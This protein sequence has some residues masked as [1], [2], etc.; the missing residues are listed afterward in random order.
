MGDKH[1]HAHSSRALQPRFGRNSQGFAMAH[2]PTCARMMRSM[3]ALWPYLPATTTHGVLARRVDTLTLVTLL[4]N[5]FFHHLVRG[6]NSSFSSCREREVGNHSSVCFACVVRP[7]THLP[8]QP[9]NTITDITMQDQ[10]LRCQS[11]GAH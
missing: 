1:A 8:T 2:A 4:P 7:V 5:S 11:K 9:V 10:G 6:L 3:L